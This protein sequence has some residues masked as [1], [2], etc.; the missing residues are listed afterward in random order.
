MNMSMLKSDQSHSVF[1]HSAVK[2][3]FSK[4]SICNYVFNSTA[5]KIKLHN[6]DTE[7]E[8]ICKNN[9]DA[10][11]NTESQENDNH[12][13]GEQHPSASLP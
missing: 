10:Y 2:L 1:D 11:K 3:L 13:D 7:S 6:E 12:C 4:F 5:P 9:S 8:L